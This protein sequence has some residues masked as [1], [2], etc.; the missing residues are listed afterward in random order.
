MGRFEGFGLRLRT[1]VLGL[2][3]VGFRVSGLKLSKRAQV[4]PRVSRALKG[5]IR[6]P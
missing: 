4:F 5:S 2:G 3:Y 6:V 1:W